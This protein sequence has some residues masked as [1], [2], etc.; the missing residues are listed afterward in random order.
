MRFGDTIMQWSEQIAQFSEPPWAEKGQLTVTYLTDAHLAT[1]RSVS[2]L[3]LEAGFD[4]V[5]TDAVGNIVGVYHGQ[6]P[7]AP[8]LLTGSHYDTVRNGGKYDGRLGILVPIAAVRDLVQRK[9]RL[10]FG[11]EVVGFAEEEGQRYRATFLAA[12]ALT[13]SFDP[14]WLAQVDSEGVTMQQ[15]MQQAG[16][17]GTL[18]SI[19]ALKRDPNTYLGFVEVHIEQGP[20]LCEGALPLG[21]V[22]SIN[23]GIRATCK[24]IG[25]AAHAGTT[26]MLMRQDAMLAAAE[27]SLMAEQRA[28]ADADSVATVGQFQVPGGSINV[29][30]GECAFTL[31]MRA[32]TDAQRDALVSDILK[33]ARAIAERRQVKFE[34]TEVMR[35]AAAPSALAWQQR[36]ERAV[37]TLGLAVHRMPS[38]AGH[39]AMKMH[40]ILPQAML[41][42]RGENSG[43]S[44]N[45][46][47]SST[48]HD[49]QLA[50]DAFALL[51]QDV[52]GA[53]P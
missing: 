21:V 13:G 15:A 43:I 23:A 18:D 31:D 42:V 9:Q 22:T 33:Q 11:I 14:A 51:L 40:D 35:A 20:V 49:M 4:D 48:S 52:A 17:P 36:W 5:S 39:D 34:Y 32:P 29:I 6:S 46:L 2:A 24:T 38:G 16:L 1:G 3:M 50:I 19:V 53:A 25:M 10:P 37:Q 8:R 45:P 12:S 30:P 47:E 44:H 27:I 41:F 28:L 26:P 7:T